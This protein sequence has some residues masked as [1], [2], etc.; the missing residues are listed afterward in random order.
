MVLVSSGVLCRSIARLIQLDYT[1]QR[2]YLI[3]LSAILLF[4]LTYKRIKR[5]T[6]LRGLTNGWIIYDTSTDRQAGD[7]ELG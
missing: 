6:S 2:C 3:M 4:H 5:L 7:T 1:E